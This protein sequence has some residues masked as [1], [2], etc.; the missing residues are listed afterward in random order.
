ML[1]DHTSYLNNCQANRMILTDVR[2]RW[3][4]PFDRIA[5]L[6]GGN[7]K[8]IVVNAICSLAAVDWAHM[9]EDVIT[10]EFIKQVEYT[11]KAKENVGHGGV[12]VSQEE[13]GGQIR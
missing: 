3:A 1:S 7:L 9:G 6:S 10:D 12:V 8:N 5:D 11:R 4:M 13:I 2:Q